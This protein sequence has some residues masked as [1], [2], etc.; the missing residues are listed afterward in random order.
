MLVYKTVLKF[1]EIYFLLVSW[2]SHTPCILEIMRPSMSES[3]RLMDLITFIY[4]VCSILSYGKHKMWIFVCEWNFLSLYVY[5]VMRWERERVVWSSSIGKDEFC[6]QEHPQE[7]LIQITKGSDLPLPFK[8]G[9]MNG[10]QRRNDFYNKYSV[11]TFKLNN[12]QAAEGPSR[13]WKGW[14][15]LITN[16]NTRI[17]RPVKL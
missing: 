10:I 9:R 4:F 17:S 12:N 7:V 14:S 3:T 15:T 11:Q 2:F 6:S 16:P 8:K 5:I 1:R 13:N